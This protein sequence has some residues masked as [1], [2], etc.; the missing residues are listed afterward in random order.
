MHRSVLGCLKAAWP[1]KWRKT[2]DKKMT[3]QFLKKKIAASMAAIACGATVVALPSLASAATLYV[4]TTGNDSNPGTITSPLQTIQRAASRAVAG[5][6]VIVR[7][8]IYRGPLSI[9][10]SGTTGAYIRFYPYPGEAAIIDGSYMSAKQDL[11]TIS[12]H[13]IEFRGFEVRNNASGSGI[14]AWCTY[15][16]NILNNAVHNIYGTGIYA[17]CDSQ[18]HS[19]D[20]DI[21]GNAVYYASMKNS[22]LCS[23]SGWNQGISAVTSD[24]SIISENL[25]YQNYGEGIGSVASRGTVI[26]GNTLHDNYS[27]DIYLD[28]SSY[29]TV[30]GNFVYNTGNPNFLRKGYHAIAIGV[31]NEGAT[32]SQ[33]LVGIKITDNIANA[34]RYG[35]YYGNYMTGGG[36]QNSTVANNTFANTQQE[37]V[38]ID[39]DKHSGDFYMN[40]IHYA[41]ASG[42]LAGG[43]PAGWTAN[44]NN[45]YGGTVPTGFA[46]A[47]DVRQ[48]P[49]LASPGASEPT[50]YEIPATSPVAKAG[51]TLSA[52]LSDF[53]GTVRTAP[54]SIGAHQNNGS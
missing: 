8:G 10:N 30:N 24:N 48:D 13:F 23:P 20:I 3:G 22:C 47:K 21:Q 53:W 17:G 33:P 39:A 19:H 18:G 31:A 12:G 7:G 15:N 36:M 32:Y 37:T 35:F 16:V 54:Y 44:Y 46:G 49:V 29:V 27:L 51:A 50:G 45:W 6:D 1:R 9:N 4:A 2:G 40:N 52:G 41:A 26:S 11:V 38:H 34:G 28:G 42:V 5:T 25:V 43:S 14:D